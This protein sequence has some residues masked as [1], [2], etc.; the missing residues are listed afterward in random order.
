MHDITAVGEYG[1]AITMSRDK[2]SPSEQQQYDAGWQANAFNGYGNDMMSLHR[3]LQDTRD[4]EY[5]DF[6]C[7]NSFQQL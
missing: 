5:V 3:A 2:L 6:Q 7:H 1:S 4:A